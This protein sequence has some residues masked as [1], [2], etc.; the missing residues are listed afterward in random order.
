MTSH[1]G[2]MVA[3]EGPAGLRGLHRER[4][5][6]VVLATSLGRQNDQLARHI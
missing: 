5:M 3:D 6:Q 1:T 2:L 4:A